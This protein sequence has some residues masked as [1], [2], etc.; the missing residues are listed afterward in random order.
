MIRN[1]TWSAAEIDLLRQ[2][3][4]C[5]TWK[6][7]RAA[8]PGRTRSAISCRATTLSIKRDCAGRVAWTC[9]ETALLRRLYPK[10]TWDEICKAIPRHRHGAI[11][12]QATTMKLRRDPARMKSKYRLI[13]ELRQIRRNIGMT[14]ARLATSI[15]IHPVQLARWERGVQL[16]RTRGLFDWIESLGCELIVSMRRGAA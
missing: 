10:A 4:P 7:M 15:G 9:V 6:V 11:A 3:Y 13:R 1:N 12:K 5:S 8:L 2:H 14:N 16:P